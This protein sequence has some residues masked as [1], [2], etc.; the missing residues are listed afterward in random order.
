MTPR[1]LTQLQVNIGQIDTL[2]KGLNINK[3]AMDTHAATIK[4]ARIRLDKYSEQF[5]NQDYLKTLS[6][7]EQKCLSDNAQALFKVHNE[8]KKELD[9]LDMTK[10]PIFVT[11]AMNELDHLYLLLDYTIELRGKTGET[12]LPHLKSIKTKDFDK[13]KYKQQ[14]INLCVE[15]ETIAN[16]F[17]FDHLGQ[18]FDLIDPM[19]PVIFDH[20]AVIYKWLA[21]E[22]KRLETEKL[23]ETK[24][25]KLPEEI[26]PEVPAGPNLNKLN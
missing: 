24:V 14:V 19:A 6:P 8:I 4:A 26:T 25:F 20:L 23:P 10:T 2:V 7:A 15:T 16:D 12:I 1:E 11:K 5:H 22:R 9:Y 3:E 21:E 18:A 13:G 17:H